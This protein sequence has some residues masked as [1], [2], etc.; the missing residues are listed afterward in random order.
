MMV[1]QVAGELGFAYFEVYIK[2]SDDTAQKESDKLFCHETWFFK[3]NLW[4][5]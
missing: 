4:N 1:V 5:F 2:I 3:A